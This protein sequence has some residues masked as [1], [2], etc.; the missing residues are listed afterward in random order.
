MARLE[1]VHPA[2]RAALLATARFPDGI[3]NLNGGR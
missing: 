1:H 3:V 2:M